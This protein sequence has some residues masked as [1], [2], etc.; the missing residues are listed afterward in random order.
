MEKFEYLK[1]F[2]KKPGSGSVY[3]AQHNVF[4]PISLEIIAEAERLL[5][6]PF[7]SQL[8]NFYYEIGGGHLT[9]PID[10]PDDY[11]CYHDNEIL[12]PIDIVEIMNDR[13]NTV[14]ISPDLELLEGDMP[15]FH[16]TDG[17]YFLVLRPSSENPNAV[18]NHYGDYID[19]FDRFIYRLYHESAD[20]FWI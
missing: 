15:F 16:V 20:Y 4:H 8:R 3:I 13:E 1:K 14:L 7:P 11:E 12:D 2:I 5:G 9:V 6:F 10:S 19:E 18:Y 17:N